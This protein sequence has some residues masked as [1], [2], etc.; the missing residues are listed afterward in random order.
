MPLQ[1]IQFKPGFNKTQTATGAEGQWIDGDNV[2]FRYGEPQKIGGWQQ[3]VNHTLAGPARDQ[4]TWTALD[5]KKYAA[6]GTSKLLVIYYEGEFFD[7]TPLDTALTSCTYTSTTG[8]ATVTINKSDHGLETGDYIKFSSVTTPGSP[9]TSYTSANFTTNVFEV[10]SVPSVNTF[11]ITMPS[12]ENG[13]G[14]TAGGT[15]TTNPY[16]TIGPTT[17]SSAFG[18]G[19]GYFGGTIPTSP[20]TLLNGAIDASVTTI[21]VDATTSFSTAPGVIDIDSEL[22]TY[23][24][25]T[26]TTFTTCGRGANGT[27]AASHSDN[28][29]VT[30]ATN[31]VNW[32]LQSNTASTTLAPGS[33]SLDNFGQILVATIKN[34]KTFTWN[35]AAVTALETRATVVANA[36]TASVMT[37]VSDRDRHLFAL[38]TETTIGDP[39]TLDPMLIRFSNQ[40]DINTWTPT[41]TNTAGTFRL[42][43]GNEIIGAVQ[44][45]DYLLVLTDQAAYV[46]QFVGPPF[47]FSV[48]QVG[49]NCGC[50]GQHAMVFAQGAVF[51][52]GIGGGF[53]VYDGT[54]KQIP[55]L[56]EDF[57]FTNIDDNLGINYGANQLVVAFY[58]SLFNEVGWFYAKNKPSPSSQVDR[59]VVYNYVENTWVTGSLARTTYSS[60]GTYDLPY[61]TQYLTTGIPTFPTINGVSSLFGSTKYWEH[62][63]GVNEVDGN[64]TETAVT[65]YIQSG[66]YDISEQ[67]LG[68]DGQLIMRVKRFVPDFKNLEGNAKITLFFRDYPANANSTPSNVY[69]TTNSTITGPFI[70]T[71]STDKV[72]TRVRGRQVSLKIENDALNET[73]RYGTLRLDIEAGGRR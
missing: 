52:M 33:W 69:T 14:V 25:K 29:V 48:R 44:G 13:T 49:T 51:W 21:T 16:V 35:P 50:I 53:F 54:V 1:K 18:Y 66:D 20:A 46:I 68:G 2:R 62:E 67:G 23:G 32:G 6:I 73:W 59:M 31:W 8:S 57:V 10:K 12:N 61:A 3:L 63:S 37:L 56:V 58:N 42:D 17:Q 43:T 19:T 60:S 64:G 11:T 7:I 28:T 45:K 24:G 5:G 70:I 47:T 55:S 27:T 41:V 39:L 72:D 9:T 15:I 34:G 38:G 30:D 36:P 65:S 40:E 22:I 4:H 71:S 26:A